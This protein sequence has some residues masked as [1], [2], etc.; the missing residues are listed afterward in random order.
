MSKRKSRR[1]G[2]S[3]G[4]IATLIIVGTLGVAAGV[5]AIVTKGFKQWGP[6]EGMVK[7][8]VAVEKFT[9]KSLSDGT[10][11]L[12]NGLAD[13]DEITLSSSFA[14]SLKLD[15]ENKIEALYLGSDEGDPTTTKTVLETT[16]ASY[17]TP[18]ADVEK[19]EKEVLALDVTK[20]SAMSLSLN[21][22]YEEENK[23]QGAIEVP[24]FDAV[25]F[26][27]KI[28]ESRLIY[29]A[30]IG[31]GT[32]ASCSYAK[33]SNTVSELYENVS[34]FE[35]GKDETV[36]QN[37]IDFLSFSLKGGNNNKI[38]IKSVEFVRTN[39]K[40]KGETCWFAQA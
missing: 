39:N 34:L 1:S 17:K 20:M 25:R 27:Y 3:K 16:L 23:A 19:I 38:E 29:T 22:A 11:V 21:V 31:S 36:S 40:H 9:A 8:G 30:D 14:G 35:I 10:L 4:L 12:T 24:Y 32:K 37:Q 18:N 26:N 6:A 2:V 33:R 15:D 13:S 7:G 5:T 28:T